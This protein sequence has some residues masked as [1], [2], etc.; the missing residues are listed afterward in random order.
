MHSSLVR[1]QN[2]FGFF[3]TVAFV[4]GMLVALSSII[5]Q[6]EVGDVKVNVR[7]VQVV[8]GRHNQYYSSK[9]TERAYIKFDLEADLE[10]LFHWNTKQVFAYLTASYPGKKYELNDAIVWD[11][12]IPSKD[13]SK[14]K[15][16]NQRGKYVINDI[17]HKFG[18][19]NATLTFGWNVQPHVGAL[20]WNEKGAGSF[21]F[22]PLK[23]KKKN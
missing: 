18:E 6:K 20:T 11:I 1:V 21:S 7:N 10:P 19:Q 23:A 9:P 14:L 12:I 22:P 2:L 8:K 17:T 15:L 3:T 5:L 4:V 16:R 13:K